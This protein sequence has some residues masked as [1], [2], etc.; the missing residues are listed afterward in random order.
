MDDIASLRLRVESLEVAT[1]DK[2]LGKLE[3]QGRKTERASKGLTRSFAAMAVP[4]A[5]VAGSAAALRKSLSI[6][7]EFDILNAGLVTATGSA[8]NAQVA[9]DAIQQFA[10]NTPY[11]LQQVTDS[12]TKLVNYGLTP[13]ERAL[14]SYGNTASALGKDLN[15]MVEAVAD[16][17]TGEFE[18]LKE[19]GIKANKQGDRVKFTFRGVATEVGN[20]AAE[21]EEYLTKLGENNFAGAMS[22]RMK[23][24]D[25]AISNLGDEWDKLWLQ[26]SQQGVGEAMAE[27]ARDATQA[28]SE[29]TA[30]L[31]S[32][33]LQAHI[34]ALTGQFDGF[35]RDMERTF[36]FMVEASGPAFGL[37]GAEGERFVKEAIENFRTLPVHIRAFLQQIYN[38]YAADT[39]EMIASA[40][41]V[42]DAIAAIFNDDTIEAALTRYNS[43]LEQIETARLAG[44]KTIEDERDAA[45]ASYEAQVDK[46][47][48]LR[49]AY[50]QAAESKDRLSQ[51]TD[52]LA[53]FGVTAPAVT[54]TVTSTEKDIADTKDTETKKTKVIEDAYNDRL[55]HASDFFGNMGQLAGTAYGKE[56]KTAKAAAIAQAT[57]K[58]YESATGAYA[59]MSG[60]P[61]V[62]PALGAAAAAAAIAAGMEN[63]NQIK[64]TSYSGAYDKGGTIPAGSFGI[65]GEIGPEIVHGPAKVIG[66]EDTAKM[67]GG[68]GGGTNVKIV[69]VVDPS[70]VGDYLATE[71]GEELIQNVVQRMPR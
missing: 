29:V 32:G 70:V 30:M 58:T 49:I 40:R 4:M 37:M 46:V 56:S 9:F 28:L 67:M 71:E 18:R 12:F 63:I 52:T 38:D 43:K 8:E 61:Y 65:V 33:Q 3:K 50:D 59:A 60:I 6:Q 25:G 57:I 41:F 45:I 19:F 1:A 17:V 39:H 26:V 64:S 44:L 24:L 16:A 22:E 13:S 11:D 15:Q 31:E 68:S 54:G 53:G 10:Q 5:A 55:N 42:R 23:T 34:A 14:S 21:I 47:D 36:D 66:R 27:G 7:R 62:G 2:R 69:N 35:H 51:G 48:Q 20:N